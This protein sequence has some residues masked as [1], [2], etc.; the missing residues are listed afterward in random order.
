MCLHG[1]FY[2][3]SEPWLATYN[4]LAAH[5]LLH[6]STVTK[7]DVPG[8]NPVGIIAGSAVAVVVCMIIVIIMV[9]IFLRRWAEI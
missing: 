2:I 7:V 8:D 6:H 9:I 4:V 5:L 1:A 3:S